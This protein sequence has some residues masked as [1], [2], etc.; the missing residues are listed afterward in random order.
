M[1]ADLDSN[2]IAEF[3]SEHGAKQRLQLLNR[4][5]PDRRFYW[6]FLPNELHR[7]REGWLM[8]N[9]AGGKKDSN[10]DMQE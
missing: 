6:K 5:N 9:R 2:R 8:I 10:A 7:P 4:A 3:R 1:E